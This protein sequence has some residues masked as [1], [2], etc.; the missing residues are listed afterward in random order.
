MHSDLKNSW[1]I[2]RCKQWMHKDFLLEL[3][4]KKM[5]RIVVFLPS[6]QGEV[7]EDNINKCFSMLDGSA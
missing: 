4:N 7:L 5:N 3:E 6:V 2:I 1:D